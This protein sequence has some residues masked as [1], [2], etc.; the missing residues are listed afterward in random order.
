MPHPHTPS[1]TAVARET[2]AAII[3]QA[4]FAADLVHRYLNSLG[5]RSTPEQPAAWPSWFLLDLGSALMIAWWEQT[6]VLSHVPESVPRSIDLIK[7]IFAAAEDPTMFVARAA[8][9]ALGVRVMTIHLR[10]FAYR[11][12]PFKAAVVLDSTRP[13]DLID[14]WARFLWR[15][16]DSRARC[17]SPEATESP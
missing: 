16:R 9:R 14:A 4:E 13:D 8:D 1:D 17:G 12:R 7:S 6:G 5:F 10:Y 2:I 11:S 3:A 15:T